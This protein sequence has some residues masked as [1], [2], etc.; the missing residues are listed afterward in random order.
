MCGASSVLAA[1]PK[2]GPASLY[3]ERCGM[4]SANPP[5]GGWDGR[6]VMTHE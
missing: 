4:L 3:A 5:P 6:F 1:V 2:D